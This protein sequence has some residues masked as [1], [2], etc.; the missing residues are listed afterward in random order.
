EGVMAEEQQ[1]GGPSG[2]FCSSCGQ[3]LEANNRFCPSCGAEARAT[4]APPFAG[5]ASGPAFG[6]GL[7]GHPYAHVPNYLIQAI[8]VTLFCCM[9]FGVVA[10]VYAAQVNGKLASGDHEGAVRTSRTAKTWVWVS[11]GVGLG[12]VA[13]WVP[14]AAC[15]TVVSG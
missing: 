5:P 6:T 1:S 9:P 3:A 7:A 2:G 11:F 14:I 8:L 13:L 4:E 15:S 12:L 10:I